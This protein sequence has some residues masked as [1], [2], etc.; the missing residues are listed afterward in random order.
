LAPAPFALN[1]EVVADMN[2]AYRLLGIQPG[3]S[4][5]EIRRAYRRVVVNTHRSGVLNLVDRLQDLS[6]AYESLKDPLNRKGVRDA[7][8]ESRQASVWSPPRAPVATGIRSEATREVQRLA[9]RPGDST[10]VARHLGGARCDRRA[11]FGSFSVVRPLG[12]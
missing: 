5:R 7:I 2:N 1:L 4:E 12:V 6:R 10:T 11:A 3:A 8:A 9:S